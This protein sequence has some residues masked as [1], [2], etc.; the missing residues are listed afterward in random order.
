M[1]IDLRVTHLKILDIVIILGV[2]KQINPKLD[3]LFHGSSTSS[4]H[5]H[6]F[7]PHKNAILSGWWF[8][9]L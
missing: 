9:P 8:E 4:I 6:H 5:Y 3:V 1:K 7:F 2:V